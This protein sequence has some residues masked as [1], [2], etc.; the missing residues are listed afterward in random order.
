MTLHV[1][2]F[3]N[4]S[5]ASCQHLQSKFPARWH[6]S[7][8]SCQPC[9][10]GAYFD[11]AACLAC[12]SSQPSLAG[13]T[14]CWVCSIYLRVRHGKRVFVNTCVKPLPWLANKPVARGHVENVRAP[15]VH[16]ACSLMAEVYPCIFIWYNIYIYIS[17]CARVH[18]WLYS[19]SP[20]AGAGRTS[21][22]GEPGPKRLPCGP[23]AK[24]IATAVAHGDPG[25]GL[26][27]T[28]FPLMSPLNAKL[29]VLGVAYILDS[30]RTN[31]GKWER[32]MCYWPGFLGGI[33][34]TT[35]WRFKA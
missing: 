23:A 19:F 22:A 7:H 1:F 27:W 17:V 10:P 16:R 35:G 18:I 15:N 9:I 28:S 33:F 14:A 12:R 8:W 4:L 3:E 26:T 30:F 21:P 2:F 6:S 31:S 13:T 24:A 5:V 20:L 32:S 34:P 29:K 25:L 11:W